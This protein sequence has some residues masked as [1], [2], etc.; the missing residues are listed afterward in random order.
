MSHVILTS[1]YGLLSAS[2]AVDFDHRFSCI[3]PTFVQSNNLDSHPDVPSHM[4]NKEILIP[5]LSESYCSHL[6]LIISNYNL[7]ADVLLGMDWISAT[8]ATTHDETLCDPSAHAVACLPHGHTWYSSRGMFKTCS[9]ISFSNPFVPDLWWASS[10]LFIVHSA[11]HSPLFTQFLS[12]QITQSSEAN[13][14]DSSTGVK[15]LKIE[16]LS[17]V[18]SQIKLKPL[19]HI[20]GVPF[21]ESLLLKPLQW[22]LQLYIASLCKGKWHIDEMHAHAANKEIAVQS[23]KAHSEAVWHLLPLLVSPSLK[24]RLVQLSHP[25]K[26]CPRW[27]VPHVLSLYLQMTLILHLPNQLIWTYCDALKFFSTVVK[28]RSCLCHIEMACWVM[29]LLIQLVSLSQIKEI[30]SSCCAWCATIEEITTPICV[31]FVGSSLPSIEWLWEN[32]KLSTVRGDKVRYAL[33][34]LKIHNLLYHDVTINNSVLDSF[35]AGEQILPVHIQHVLPNDVQDSLTSWYDLNKRLQQELS[36]N[37]P[38]H[39]EQCSHIPFENVLITDIDAHAPANELH[40]AAV[41]HI[42][43]KGGA[44]IQVPHDA[45]PVNEFCNTDLFPMIYPTLF[46]YGLGGFKNADDSSL[47]V[48]GPW[49]PQHKT[50]LSL[51]WHVK[52]LI[53]LSD[54]WFQE[55][56]S[57]L[58]TTFNILQ[59]HEIMLQSS[60]KVKKSNFDETAAWLASVSFKAVH[61]VT[62]CVSRGDYTMAHNDEE[63][64]THHFLFNCICYHHECSILHCNLCHSSHDMSYLLSHP[65]ATFA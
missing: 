43:K 9:P 12:T 48:N 15:L 25:K 20:H 23:L 33:N 26:P 41:Q 27:L 1:F 10:C 7:T 4:P 62:E 38:S 36:T 17:T 37:N 63:C 49:Q 29:F 13:P 42:K 2:V 22:V 53:S 52:H 32:D 18:Q 28:S 35:S 30:M 50:P 19:Q 34:W 21:N 44:Y 5:T 3:S 47:I 57:F 40:A 55:H 64:L 6:S 39:S 45:K 31:V 11:S 56:Y 54:K 14:S 24:Q 58:F 16:L 60:L 65:E 59:Q 8:S 61:S 51:K 46:P